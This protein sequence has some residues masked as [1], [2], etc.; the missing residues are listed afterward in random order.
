MVLKNQYCHTFPNGG[1]WKPYLTFKFVV[2][3]HQFSTK[4]YLYHFPKLKLRNNK[5]W[6]LHKKGWTS[7]KIYRYLKKN[8]FKVSKY[9]SSINNIIQRRI[10][11]EKV[12]NQPVELNTFV[13]FGMEMIR[14]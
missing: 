1:W 11:K 3:T 4:P 10:K 8:G 2:V 14:S 6:E 13:D 5:I 7:T 9:P 12:L